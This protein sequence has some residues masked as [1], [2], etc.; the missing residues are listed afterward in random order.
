MSFL[1]DRWR[2]IGARL[3]LALGFAVALTLVS[4]A[5]GVYYFEQSGDANYQVRS[6][7][8]PALEASWAA[9]REAE[10]LRNLG[11]GLVAAESGFQGSESEA[12]AGSLERLETALS[13]VR[14]VPELAPL[15]ASVSDA[16]FA[17]VDLEVIDELTLSRD[18][19]QIANEAAADYRLR[20]ATTTS[21]IGESD[22]ALSVLQQALQAGEE[23][24]LDGLWDEFSSLYAAGVDPAVASL[25]E[26][27]GV[28]FVRGRQLALEANIRDLALSFDASSATLVNSVSNLLEASGAQ[29]SESLTLAVSSFDEGRTLLTAISVISVIAATLA[30]WLWVGNGMVRRLSRM[31][32]R[33]RRMADGDLETPVPEVGRDEIGELAAAL[34]VFRQ[35]ALEVQRLNLV[36]QLYEELRQTN[37]ELERT[38][39]R[40]VAQEKLAALGELVAGVAHEISNPLNFVTNFSEGSLSLYEELSEML[41][42]YREGM[43]QE[44]TEL[45]DNITQELTNS[46]NRVLANGGRALAIVERMRA[47]GVIGGEP[48]MTDLNDVVRTAVQAACTAFSAKIENFTVQPDFDLDPSLGEV[49][50]VEGDFIE[51]MVNLV[52]NACQAMYQ[53]WEASD[54]EYA[55]ELVITTR[56]AD[57]LAEVR[58]RDN[59]TGIADDVIG[60]IFN[61][62]FTTHAGTLGAGLGLT[63]A[64]D[65]ARRL[66]GDL[67]VDTLYGEYAEFT[68]SVPVAAGALQE[69]AEDQG[70]GPGR[71]LEVSH[72]EQRCCLAHPFR[73]T[74]PAL[75]PP[76]YQVCEH[77]CSKD[78]G[79]GLD[80]DQRGASPGAGR[81]VAQG[82][83]DARYGV[84]YYR[85]RGPLQLA[86]GRPQRRFHSAE[87]G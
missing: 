24:S 74:R 84:A 58:V 87:R 4:G 19:L 70:P 53:K 64:A 41:D 75:L 33:M 52:S 9:A 34:E 27:E 2:R 69:A 68:M 26:G 45:L 42:T 12:V 50:L 25:G 54:H 15:T 83:A 43:S 1:M 78:A 71:R 37:A 28:F 14:S 48:V 40:L 8:V 47:L 35:Q 6:E 82:V 67:S 61:P 5:V 7:S 10:R 30:A 62:F 13:Q 36:E 49:P 73:E 21:D 23:D 56:L 79:K 18:E 31:S 51:A 65:V 46:L 86:P 72:P 85:D 39:A 81:N 63:I 11:L 57:G 59:G 60:Y 76:Q 77:A 44:D 66:G 22:A 17:G 80:D 38:Q 16:A 20:L 29:S 55:P 32:E 3:Y